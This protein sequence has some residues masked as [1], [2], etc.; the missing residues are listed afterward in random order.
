MRCEGDV[1]PH[2]KKSYV[3][4]QH[5]FAK[6][7]CD[8]EMNPELFCP[9][10]QKKIKDWVKRYEIQAKYE[11]PAAQFQLGLIAQIKGDSALAQQHF[12]AAAKPPG[13]KAIETYKAD[14]QGH[15][16]AQFMLGRAFGDQHQH[17]N[18]VKQGYG[19]ALE[20]QS[21]TMYGDSFMQLMEKNVSGTLL[22]LFPR[23][24]L[25]TAANYYKSP[26]FQCDCST[27]IWHEKNSWETQFMFL[28]NL[29]G[30]KSK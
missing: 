29:V 10:A 17:E 2:A 20:A 12:N 18:A 27:L 26:N 21:S 11:N 30:K 14:K 19:P 3:P 24:L 4:A 9:K 22:E 5:K 25:E 7:Y 13:P 1:N 23:D 28:E 6:L 15:A 8:L 16:P